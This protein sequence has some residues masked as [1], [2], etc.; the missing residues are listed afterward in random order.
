[1]Q[2]ESIRAADVAAVTGRGL[3]PARFAHVVAGRTKRR[4]G[5]A[6]G[7]RSF[8]V[9]L[10]TL[11]PGAASALYHA[12]TVQDEFVFVLEGRVTIVAGDTE[13]EAGPGE[14]IGFKGGTGIAHQLVNRSGEPM[15]YLEI[16]DRQPGDGVEYPRDDLAA[17]Q[18]PGGWIVTHKDGTPY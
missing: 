4:L 7:L 1:M 9:N 8:G 10:T 15:T 11:E 17:K 3:Y 14:C 5:D 16:G 18:G 12:H 2:K 13:Y 6:F